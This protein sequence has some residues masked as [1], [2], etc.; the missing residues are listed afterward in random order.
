MASGRV[1]RTT[2]AMIAFMAFFLSVSSKALAWGAELHFPWTYMYALQLGYP[3]EDAYLMGIMNYNIDFG[4]TSSFPV[5]GNPDYH[6]NTN[7]GKGLPDSRDLKACEHL[8]ASWKCA[9]TGNDE[10]FLFNTAAALHAVQDKDAH[11]DYGPLYHGFHFIMG[12]IFYGNGKY[13]SWLDDPYSED[14]FTIKSNPTAFSSRGINTLRNTEYVLRIQKPFYDIMMAKDRQEMAESICGAW[15]RECI[16]LMG[17]VQE[18]AVR[19]GGMAASSLKAA[20]SVPGSPFQSCCDMKA[21]LGLEEMAAPVRMAFA[22]SYSTDLGGGNDLT[23]DRSPVPF[24]E[25]SE[26]DERLDP[27]DGL[28]S[29]CDEWFEAVGVLDHSQPID[30]LHLIKDMFMKRMAREITSL[31]RQEELLQL[32]LEKRPGLQ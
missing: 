24:N 16:S 1:Y 4:D 17:L 9:F 30:P 12:T 19:F 15:I 29:M 32:R 26:P 20:L 23:N 2:A 8:L 13:Y 28:F 31:M 7:K 11:L 27:F 3:H 22:G 6:T 21:L 14:V 10:G 25:V 18:E 5:I